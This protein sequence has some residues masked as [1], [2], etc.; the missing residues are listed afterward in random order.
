V[1]I[2]VGLTWKDCYYQ[3]R[4]KIDAKAQQEYRREREVAEKRASDIRIGVWIIR[5]ARRGYTREDRDLDISALCACAI[6]L[7]NKAIPTWESILR[8]HN[9]R[10]LAAEHCMERGMLPEVVHTRPSFP[11]GD[12]NPPLTMEHFNPPYPTNPRTA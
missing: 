10:I 3:P 12:W 6:V 1:L 11:C 2:A 9:E 8:R 4:T 7:T 5:F